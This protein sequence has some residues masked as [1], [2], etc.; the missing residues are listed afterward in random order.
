MLQCPTQ[1]QVSMMCSPP[2]VYVGIKTKFGRHERYRGSAKVDFVLCVCDSCR[3]Q[4]AR[5]LAMPHS[6]ASYAGPFNVG[7][8]TSGGGGGDV[9][10]DVISIRSASG[11]GAA[12]RTPK[13]STKTRDIEVAAVVL[14]PLLATHQPVIRPAQSPHL[15]SRWAS[16]HR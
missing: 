4:H 3:T 13:R 5:S 6:R 15:C 7:H 8:V 11:G 9:H 12:V 1:P 10:D 2:R 14:S 16:I